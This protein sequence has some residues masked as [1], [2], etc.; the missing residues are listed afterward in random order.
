MLVKFATIYLSILKNVRRL[1]PRFFLLLPAVTLT[2]FLLKQCVTLFVLLHFFLI[3]SNL[4]FNSM[5][6]TCYLCNCSITHIH[7][8]LRICVSFSLYS[9]FYLVFFLCDSDRNQK[10]ERTKSWRVASQLVK[11]H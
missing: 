5:S 9:S 11:L 7:F 1:R 3:L 6:N 4:K 2:T 10:Q 8:C